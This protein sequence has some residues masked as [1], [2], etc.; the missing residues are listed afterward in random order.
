M[1]ETVRLSD[2]AR[3]QL[4]TVKRRTGVANWNIICRWAFVLSLKDKSK[5]ALEKIE[6]NG[7]IEMTWRTFAGSNDKL[8]LALLMK[9]L[10]DDGVALDKETVNDYFKT[11]LHRGISFLT[12]SKRKKLI[13]YI[14]LISNETL[15]G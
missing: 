10:K 9:R 12:D 13:D 1:I 15:L 2:R 4:M 14:R 5:P 6:L 8:F 3:S 7:A 11:Y